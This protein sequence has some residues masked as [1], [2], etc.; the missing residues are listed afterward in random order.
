MT[1]THISGTTRVHARKIANV[2]VLTSM[3]DGCVVTLDDGT[4]M[5]LT[6][7]QVLKH[8]PVVGDYLLGRENGNLHVSSHAS[9][10]RIFSPI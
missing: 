1:P 8:A 7:H 5:P 9:F 2:K 6:A 3:I 4:V 10:T